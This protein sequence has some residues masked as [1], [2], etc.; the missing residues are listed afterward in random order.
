MKKITRRAFL[1]ASAW[2]GA[3]AAL[4]GTIPLTASAAAADT[5]N[6]TSSANATVLRACENDEAEARRKTLAR[7]IITTDVECDDMNGLI[8]TAFFSGDMD[9]VGVVRSAGEWRWDGERDSKDYSINL[10]MTLEES[11][12]EWVT[13][14]NPYPWRCRGE[15]PFSPNFVGYVQSGPKS[16]TAGSLTHYR[17][18]N[19]NWLNELWDVYYREAYP[20]LV[21]HDPSYPT[22]EYMLSI[23]KRGNCAFESDIRYDTEGSKLIENEILKLDDKR[24]LVI[25]T[26]GGA[27]TFVRALYSIRLQYE[28]TPQWNDILEHIR[29]T[30]Y[31]SYYGEDDCWARSGLKNVYT[32]ASG[33]PSS[34]HLSS[35]GSPDLAATANPLY[36]SWSWPAHGVTYDVYK[37]YQGKWLGENLKENHGSLAAHYYTMLDGQYIGA[38]YKNNAEPRIYQW[39]R[40]GIH[41]CSLLAYGAYPGMEKDYASAEEYGPGWGRMYA[42]YDWT[43]YQSTGLAIG[44]GLGDYTE[45]YDW[46]R[47]GF[48][49]GGVNTS[50]G[51][52]AGISAMSSN[53]NYVSGSSSGMATP[54]T[55]A[56][57]EELAARADWCIDA[58][59]TANNPPVILVN[60][61]PENNKSEDHFVYGAPG[62]TVVLRADVSDPDGDKVYTSWW[63]WPN[64]S[65]YSG[66]TYDLSPLNPASPVTTFTIPADAKEGEYFNF[67]IQARD[68]DTTG[69]PMTRF[70]NIVVQVSSQASA[71]QSEANLLAMA[72]DSLDT[73]KATVTMPEKQ[74]AKPG[75]AVY[76]TAG[77]E[78]AAA[79]EHLFWKVQQTNSKKIKGTAKTTYSG[80]SKLLR[81]WDLSEYTTGFTVPQDAKN[82]E[83]IVVEMW[84]AKGCAT[85]VKYGETI[86]TVADEL[87][88]EPVVTSVTAYPTQI[89]QGHDADIT[90][91]VEGKNLAGR[92][93]TATILGVTALVENG[94]AV[95]HLT[96][97]DVFEY[98]VFKTQVE[99]EGTWIKSDTD[100]HSFIHAYTA[101]DDLK[102]AT[103]EVSENSTTITF[104]AETQKYAETDE[105]KQYALPVVAC[106]KVQIGSTTVEP[107]KVT[108]SGNSIIIATTVAPGRKIKLF[109]VGFG[110]L[111]A[112]EG[113]PDITLTAPLQWS[114]LFSHR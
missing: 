39:G 48:G 57:W 50:E 14:E 103:I 38:D 62:E 80:K 59:G 53:G 61:L 46:G 114:R 102:T 20:N 30:V 78:N 106:R 97:D 37:F 99:V 28:N 18:A 15:E 19:D 8:T 7:L 52:H 63:I 107:S 36:G 42:K 86:I 71:L 9:I 74:T 10:G 113:T 41:N 51:K 65:S 84:G 60:G 43:G 98:G 88:N 69:A 64:A 94:T 49:Y 79:N 4:T 81:T 85:P 110:D 55:R 35:Y 108:T 32:F 45:A 54:F 23:T 13:E 17:E 91:T 3:A 87:P 16:T 34:G 27:N 101:P 95:V 111:F 92:N 82:G 112:E 89:L 26:M 72:V 33:N 96:A 31:A 76:L 11:M 90:V 104:A 66:S 75:C 73:G 77:I 70:S 6:K 83:T 12:K 25:S 5:I 109:D 58:N 21:A 22:P 100:P 56:L 44:S 40:T 67:I 93:V 68:S 24:P 105:W 2:T 29:T 47:W 1:Q